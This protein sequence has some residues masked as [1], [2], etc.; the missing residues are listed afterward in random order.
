[1]MVFLK[2][3]DSWHLKVK[4][5]PANNRSTIYGSSGLIFSNFYA[6][7]TKKGFVLREILFWLPLFSTWRFTFIRI[8]YTYTHASLESCY[9]SVVEMSQ[10][11]SKSASHV[12]KLTSS[13]TH[14]QIDS[15]MGVGISRK[16]MLGFEFLENKLHNFF[17]TFSTIFCTI[18]SHIF[19]ILNFF[20][21]ILHIFWNNF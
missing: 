10:K 6:L 12:F 7:V 16:Y 3:F 19:T 2:L 13:L 17:K 11:L 1:M 20:C 18:F 15:L 8:S 9:I 4:G 14:R 5:N 21:T